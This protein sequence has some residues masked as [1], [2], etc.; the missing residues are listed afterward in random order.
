MS[1]N[2]VTINQPN[3][4]YGQPLIDN[5]NQ[6]N[7]FL[8][9][10]PEQSS[11]HIVRNQLSLAKF[12]I[13]NE[14]VT[15]PEEYA[16]AFGAMHN[17]WYNNMLGDYLKNENNGYSD[18][19][20]SVDKYLKDW[21]NEID[22]FLKNLATACMKGD[23]SPEY[24]N[25]LVYNENYGIIHLKNWL[26]PFCRSCVDTNGIL[27]EQMCEIVEKTNDHKCPAYKCQTQQ[28][29][30]VTS[31]QKTHEAKVEQ[32]ASQTL[33]PGN[34]NFINYQNEG[35]NFFLKIA[36][37]KYLKN[38]S[39][40]PA[41]NEISA[42]EL[43]EIIYNFKI[44]SK[45]C[46]QGLL[47]NSNNT[48][49]NQNPTDIPYE[50]PNAISTTDIPGTLPTDNSTVT[51]SDKNNSALTVGLSV[52]GLI[53]CL[54]AAC[55]IIQCCRHKE[56]GCLRGTCEDLE[57]IFG[58]KKKEGNRDISNKSKNKKNKKE[59]DKDSANSRNDK[60]CTVAVNDD[61]L[62]SKDVFTRKGGNIIKGEYIDEKDFEKQ[63][64]DL[65][66]QADDVVENIKKANDGNESIA[67]NKCEDKNTSQLENV[68]SLCEEEQYQHGNIS[69][70]PEN[71]SI[72]SQI[73]G[74]N[75]LY[76]TKQNTEDSKNNRVA[77]VDIE[78][79]NEYV[80]NKNEVS[81]SKK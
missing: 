19:G 61:A 29:W 63:R 34:D 36:L 6:Q 22:F 30:K 27:K 4:P 32:G 65:R 43:Q 33:S 66:K 14:E 50:L 37:E 23:L 81:V 72:S 78:L 55:I 20:W 12:K 9:F 75:K 17:F 67:T 5:N 44:A 62:A 54:A 39:K 8:R 48:L 57:R 31:N 11:N 64:D 24:L 40:S 76:G 68:N 74:A 80:A 25:I 47:H 3:N 71:I 41:N 58:C 1:N 52:G 56:K 77:D 28:N 45:Q 69:S 26:V 16:E 59:K 13:G 79:L 10:M 49:I 46:K 53:T 51:E 38:I 15:V 42:K 7:G 60:I 73:E 2:N 18:S 70:R 21:E 35:A